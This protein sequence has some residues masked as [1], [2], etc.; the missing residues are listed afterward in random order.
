MEK[1]MTT[2]VAHYLDV[3]PEHFDIPTS[4]GHI[5]FIALSQ[6]S[7]SLTREVAPSTKERSL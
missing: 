7:E 3:P 2:R 6:S 4:K 5:D 1:V